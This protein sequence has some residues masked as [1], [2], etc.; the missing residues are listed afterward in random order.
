MTVLFASSTLVVLVVG[1]ASRSGPA[2][3]TTEPTG[4][5][6]LIAVLYAFPVAMALATGIEAPAGIAELGR[7]QDAGRV[8]FAG[9]AAGGGSRPLPTH[10]ADTVMEHRRQVPC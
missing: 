10:W 3:G 6:P 7:L 5:S 9:P 1:F 2:G 4:G 8:R